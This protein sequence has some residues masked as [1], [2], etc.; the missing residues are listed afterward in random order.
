MDYQNKAGH[1]NAER[2]E[3]M[4]VR[5]EALETSLNKLNRVIALLTERLEQQD[6]RHNEQT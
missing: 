3:V 1:T 4:A 2:I 6:K 5:V